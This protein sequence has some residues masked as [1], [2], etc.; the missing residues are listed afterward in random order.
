MGIRRCAAAKKPQIFGG[1]DFMPCAGRNESTIP[2]TDF[3][4]FIT[5]LQNATPLE[6]EVKFLERAVIMPLRGCARWQG[7]LRKALIPHRGVCGIEDTSDLR[8]VFGDER[9]LTG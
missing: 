4:L 5:D 3:P 8:T 1:G 9:F 7:R 2:G 6:N